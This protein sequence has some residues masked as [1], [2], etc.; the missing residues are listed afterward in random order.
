[1]IS[2]MTE[3]IDKTIQAEWGSCCHNKHEM[4]LPFECSSVLFFENAKI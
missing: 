3:P 2:V 4:S 1:M